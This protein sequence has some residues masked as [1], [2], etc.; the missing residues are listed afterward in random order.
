MPYAG[1]AQPYPV[2]QPAM[3]LIASITNSFPAIVTTTFNN[4]YITGTIVRFYIP[5]ACGMQQ[6]NQQTATIFVIN[7]TTFSIPVDTT[8][9]DT[10][11]IPSPSDPAINVIAQVVP[12]GEDNGILT[13]ATTNVLPYQ[14]TS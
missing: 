4:Q 2:F 13:A 9:Y 5:F 3:R 12:I 10:F 6:L 8:M 7:P 11:S 1:V 14:A